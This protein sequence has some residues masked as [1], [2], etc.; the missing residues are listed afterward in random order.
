LWTIAV[1]VAM[2]ATLSA[3]ESIRFG[4]DKPAPP[5]QT[6]APRPTT[7]TPVQPGETPTAGVPS[8][9]NSVRVALLLPFSH[10]DKGTRAVAQAL[11]NAA[12]MA[13]F[14]MGSR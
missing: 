4:G 11:L 6:E 2:G 14:D 5:R 1:V 12:Q 8:N 9:P 10:P 3:C 7:V 13:M